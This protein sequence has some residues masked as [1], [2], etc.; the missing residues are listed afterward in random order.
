MAEKELTACTLSDNCR[1]RFRIYAYASTWFGC[2]SDVMLE[3]SA[4]IILYF[5]MLGTD[6]TLIML[7]TGLIGIVSMFLLIPAS[8]IVDRLGPKRV[9][10]LASWI[11]CGSYLLMAAAPFAGKPAAPYLVL[12]GCFIFS[13]SR[14]LTNAAWYP[15]LSAILK[16]S[17]R[18]DFFGFMRFSYY[19]L[20][21]MVFCLL[22][23]LM[24]AEPPV[25]FL[26]LIIGI[27]GI[28]ALGRSVFI[29]RIVLPEETRSKTHDFHG[30]LKTSVCN[31]PLVGFSVYICCQSFAFA[32]ILPLT[33]LYLKNGLHYGDNY[34][35]ILSSGGIAGSICGFFFYGS[36]VRRLG[37]RN[38][39]FAIHAAYILIPLGLFFCGSGVPYLPLLIGLL[40]FAGN[41]AFSCFTCAFSQESL[42]LARPGNVAMAAAFTLTYQM[43]GTAVGRTAAS[44]LLGNGILSADWSCGGISFSHYQ[45]IFLFSSLLALFFLTL[46]FCIPSVVPKHENYYNP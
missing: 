9:I 36:L 17:E 32:A 43:I 2:F 45:T 6:N 25:W 10:A 34:V 1:R 33:L 42:A 38:L 26:Q 22:G 35:Q 41:A 3:N 40:L 4:V 5:V 27:T 28:L 7:S 20:T 15:V 14:P 16:P 44:L 11:A 8:G 21:G 19:I 12:L 39:Q 37:I 23:I 30:A 29:S 31:G 18:G 46:V 13:V 24:G